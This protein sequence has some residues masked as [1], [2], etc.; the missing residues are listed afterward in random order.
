MTLNHAGGTKLQGKPRAQVRV[1]MQE[2]A[3]PRLA[4][5]T[6]LVDDPDA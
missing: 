5:L 3:L 4:A 6:V 1:V 2:E